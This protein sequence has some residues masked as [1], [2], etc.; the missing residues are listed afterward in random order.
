[1]NGY[2]QI[3]LRATGQV[4]EMVPDVA[5]QLISSGMA[6]EVRSQGAQPES[7]MVQPAAERA[8]APAQNGPSKKSL[9]SRVSK[10]L[11]PRNAG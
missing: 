3:R 1:M 2:K 11:S 5:R 4:T 10:S 7:M 8:I 6:E 9:L